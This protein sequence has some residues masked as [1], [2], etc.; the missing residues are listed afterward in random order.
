MHGVKKNATGTDRI[1]CRERAIGMH[2]S[3]S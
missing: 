3:A 1:D 2:A